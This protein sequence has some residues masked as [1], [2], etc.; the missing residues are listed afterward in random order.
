MKVKISG[1]LAF[2]VCSFYSDK[3][4]EYLM[5]VLP[6]KRKKKLK[7][8]IAKIVLKMIEEKSQEI[9]EAADKIKTDGV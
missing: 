7:K 3:D 4:Y 2:Y 5:S 9:L 8:E 1:D 6:R